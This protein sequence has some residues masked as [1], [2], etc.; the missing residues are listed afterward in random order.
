MLLTRRTCL[1]IVALTLCA[2]CG[3]AP[4]PVIEDPTAEEPETETAAQDAPDPACAE[5][6]VC[7]GD[8]EVTSAEELEE[9]RGCSGIVGDLLLGDQEWLTNIDL[10]CLT[11]II[12][13]LGI[14][15]NDALAN[16]DGLRNLARVSSH[17]II[18][19]NDTLTNL[20][21]LQGL[22]SLG[23][24]IIRDNNA[25][26]NVD[27]L[28]H[29]TYFS[30]LEISDNDAL[31]NLDGLRSITE[32]GGEVDISNNATLPTF[33]NFESLHTYLRSNAP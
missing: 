25:L 30:G 33:D 20:N 8:Y 14:A 23:M 15:R 4:T 6:V 29:V 26:A 9:L 1:A 21:G 22:T 17:L 10:P 27:G 28:G 18:V 32:V 7:D 3:H 11:A 19:Q 5:A 31:A 16:V 2:A 24:V 12:G 13:D